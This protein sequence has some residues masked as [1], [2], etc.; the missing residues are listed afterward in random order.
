LASIFAVAA[1]MGGSWRWGFLCLLPSAWAVLIKFAIMGWL[2]IPIGVATSMFAAMTLGLGVNCAIHLLDGMRQAQAAG[3]P[4]QEV[5]TRA[6]A[7][8][9]PPALINTLAVCLGFGTLIFSHVPANARLGLLL[10]IG[11]ASC[12]VA[13]MTILPVLLSW[14]SQS[15]K[16]QGVGNR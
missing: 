3:T 11:L 4:P 8:T 6:L 7:S 10:A 12:F 14:K 15:A 5:L 2:N 13:S 9:G 16:D 1:F